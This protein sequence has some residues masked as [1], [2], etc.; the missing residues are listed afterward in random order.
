[1]APDLN[2]TIR[3]ATLDDWRVIAEFNTRL[4]QETEGKVLNPSIIAAGVK[5]LLANPA[6]GRYF[7]ACRS[8]QIIG[9][10]MHTHEWSDWRNGEIWW[11]QSVYVHPNFRQ[12]GIFRSLF[13]YL[14]RLASNDPNVIGLRLYAESQNSRAL[15]VYHALGFEAS[16]YVVLERFFQKS[17]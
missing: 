17:V 11:L 5:A 12:M 3:P 1:M 4:A 6:R 16:G 8:N 7:V 14:E 13:R 9:Q 15:D 2:I 10:I